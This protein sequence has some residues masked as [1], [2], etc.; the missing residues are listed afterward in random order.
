[1]QALLDDD[2]QQEEHEQ[3]SLHLFNIYHLRHQLGLSASFPPFAA[4]FAFVFL[5]SNRM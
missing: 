5:E 1:M 3:A 4:L 2:G